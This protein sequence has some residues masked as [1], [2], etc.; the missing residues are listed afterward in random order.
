MEMDKLPARFRD[1]IEVTR[2]LGY[3]YLW[4]DPLC[5][6]Q[7][8]FDDWEAESGR[9]QD[10]YQNAMLVIAA[11][12]NAGDHCGFLHHPTLSGQS[13]P[14]DCLPRTIVGKIDSATLPPPP[15][16]PPRYS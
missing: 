6:L 7:D 15:L 3:L 16:P 1:A 4:I 12:N 11:D 13:T 14:K 10:Y 2:R 5:I 9:I 8:S